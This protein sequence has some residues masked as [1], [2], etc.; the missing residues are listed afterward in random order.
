MQVASTDTANVTQAPIAGAWRGFAIFAWGVLAYNILVILWG[1][2]VRATGSGAGC[3]GHWPLCNGNVLP[4]VSQTATIIEFTHRIMSGV[5]LI[6]VA[7]MFVWAW[8]TFPKGHSAR[9]WAAWSVVFILTEALIGAALVLLGHVAKDESAGR[10][11]SLAT[12]LVNTFLLLASMAL[13]A[14]WA[15]ES[16]ES[17]EA[18]HGKSNSTYSKSVLARQGR[19]MLSLCALVVVAVAGAIT[20]LGDTLFPPQSFAQAIADDFSAASRFLIRLRVI[21]PAL[22]VAAGAL[23]VAVALPAFR[24]TAVSARRKLAGLLLGLVIAE[25]AAGGLTVLLKA[26]VAM[27]LVHLLIADSLWISLVLF[28]SEN[29]RQN[30]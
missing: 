1:A 18:D 22:A 19:V 17:S 11:Y 2:L 10:A 20:A 24:A 29:L 26:P 30:R 3:G 5:A 16:P 7:A 25:V 23:I 8:K 15:R 21:H 4:E 14:W 12:H 27:Q 28:S 9:R 13:T 6:A